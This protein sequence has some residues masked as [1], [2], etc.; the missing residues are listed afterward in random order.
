[1]WQWPENIILNCWFINLNIIMPNSVLSYLFDKLILL[2]RV[3]AWYFS[4]FIKIL[5]VYST[6]QGKELRLRDYGTRSK[7]F[8]EF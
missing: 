3:V 2:L 6:K 5:I 8:K 1:M 7:R 4:F